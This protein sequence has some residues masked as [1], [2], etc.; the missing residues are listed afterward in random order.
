MPPLRHLILILASSLAAGCVSN[1]ASLAPASPA[2]ATRNPASAVAPADSQK[3]HRVVT[4]V[5]TP[6]FGRKVDKLPSIDVQI[7]NG[8]SEPVEFSTEKIA[9]FADDKPIKVYGVGEYMQLVDREIRTDYTAADVREQSAMIRS[10]WSDNKPGATSPLQ[11]K[12]DG[13]A[14]RQDI[15]LKQ[16]R[17]L[18]GLHQMLQPGAI[19]PGQTLGGTIRLEGIS[20]LSAQRLRLRI[21]VGSETHEVDFAVKR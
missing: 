13:A 15:K 4:R 21:V 8:G 1:S 16:T 6:Q 5:L 17:L 10:Q 7:T 11:A 12:M 18:D 9:A 2:P 3:V 19:A 14:Q 20:L